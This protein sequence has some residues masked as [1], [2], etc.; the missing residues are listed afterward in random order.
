MT[1]SSDSKRLFDYA[2]RAFAFLFGIGVAIGILELYLRTFPPW[3][4]VQIVRNKITRAEGAEIAG[5]GTLR[6]QNGVPI[7]GTDKLNHRDCARQHPER[8]RVLFFGDS[9]TRGSGIDDAEV[10][11]V[12]LEQRLNM[13]RPDP[14]FCVMNFA[15]P[16]F[17][18]DQSYAIA[19]TEIPRQHAVLVFWQF[20]DQ[21]RAYAMLGDDEA[22]ARMETYDLHADGFPYP[23]PAA[24]LPNSVNRWLF[25]H[26]RTYE[27]LTLATGAGRPP[28]ADLM[29]TFVRER[30]AKLLAL[31][32]SER[33]RAVFYMAT[34]LDKSFA[35]SAVDPQLRGW[36]DAIF[37]AAREAGIETFRLQDAFRERDYLSLRLDSCCHFNAA[38]HRALA[39]VFERTVLKHLDSAASW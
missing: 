18:F 12:L 27:Y 28:A 30:L 32:R 26:L 25:L 1:S 11:T 10:F 6:M 39:D 9:I 3:P 4:P 23:R 33:S 22:Y 35:E 15:Q 24:Y 5:A 13:L 20:W 2:G 8:Q 38:G 19:Q 29:G 14:G 34:P 36:S 21:T 7:W 16:G 17:G 31:L 37:S